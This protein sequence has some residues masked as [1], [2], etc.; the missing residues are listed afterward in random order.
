MANKLLRNK[1]QAIAIVVLTIDVSAGLN[2]LGGQL[3]FET[4]SD[5]LQLGR[6]WGLRR[7]W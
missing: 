3:T 6:D 5:A 2:K 1:I 4:F 7:L